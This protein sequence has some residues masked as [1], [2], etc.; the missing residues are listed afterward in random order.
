MT[1]R[2]RVSVCKGPDCRAGGSD[3]VFAAARA[4]VAQAGL[5]G[6]CELMRGGCY[7]LCQMG[8]NVVVR[9]NDGRPQDPFSR[10]N[11]ELLGTPGEVHYAEM[12]Q[13]KV[14]EVLRRHILGGEPIDAFRGVRAQRSSSKTGL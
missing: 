10:G 7:G 9:P 2:F 14:V 12:T 6:V 4:E 3:G 8:P 11:Y 1:Q 5:A 13:E